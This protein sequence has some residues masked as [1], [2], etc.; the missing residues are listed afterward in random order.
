MVH[1]SQQNKTRDTFSHILQAWIGQP[2]GKRIESDGKNKFIY[3]LEP[4]PEIWTT[5]LSHRTQILYLA[6]ISLICL[7][8]ELRPGSFVL[9]SGTGSGSL[10]HALARAVA[11][12]GKVNTFEFHQERADIAAKEFKQHGLG[13]I[14]T[15]THRNIEQDGFPDTF[16]SRVDAVFLDLPSPWKAILSAG[17]CLRPD[18][19]FCGFSP[20]IEQVQKT[21]ESLNAHGFRDI[22]MIELLLKDYDVCLEYQNHS[23]EGLLTSQ[24]NPSHKNQ[25]GGAAKKVT[26]TDE[27]NGSA[28]KKARIEGKEESE[29]DSVPPH[30][31]LRAKPQ[32]QG[33]GHT[34]YLT[35]ARKG[36]KIDCM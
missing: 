31:V 20:C 9:E 6:D 29:K 34:G 28:V 32:M 22:R 19:L 17:K 24:K 23:V 33:K 7:Q 36:V 2:F 11:P 27:T 21:C 26:T 30:R 5:V 13:H 1:S 25:R 16:H 3:L 12:I 18:G 10:T 4:T 35:F 14:V 8:L 15:V